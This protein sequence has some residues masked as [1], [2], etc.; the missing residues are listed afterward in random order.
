[1][2]EHYV[3]RYEATL[4]GI[5]LASIDPAVA[6]LDVQYEK[7]K[8]KRNLF[9]LANRNGARPGTRY[10]DRAA[11]TI[12]FE[13]HEQ[14]IFKRQNICQEIIAW[15]KDGGDLRINDR[16]GQKL[17]C[18]CDD[19][20]SVESVRNWTNE[21]TITFAA[22]EC[23]YWQ[24]VTP[25]VIECEYS[26][27]SATTLEDAFEEYSMTIP[28]NAPY[29]LLEMKIDNFTNIGAYVG[30]QNVS[31]D[32]GL[33]EQRGAI[34]GGTNRR[35]DAIILEYDEN[36]IMQYYIYEYDT[37]QEVYYKRDEQGWLVGVDEV[38]LNCGKTN[39]IK[40]RHGQLN[41]SADPVT[42]T[43][44]AC[45]VTFTARGLWE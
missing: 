11:V 22:Y 6:V 30:V 26:S 24:E 27:R 12:L 40:F 34:Y 37:V 38:R 36:M 16:P 44:R 32:D 23:P 2:S 10:K 3:S 7:P 41:T 9:Q 19:F 1:M 33:F 14:N 35:Q 17:I 18:V 25:T 39:T 31:R 42:F 21:M 8:Y 28:G 15:A 20:P 29:T 4:N 13:I 5:S 43:P 45:T